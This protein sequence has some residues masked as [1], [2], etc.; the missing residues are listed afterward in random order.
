[1]PGDP[2]LEDRPL[3]CPVLSN[4]ENDPP[5]RTAIYEI[6]KS[7]GCLCK[8][9]GLSHDRFDRTRLKQRDNSVPSVP[10]GLLRLTEHVEAQDAGLWHDEI[11][12]VNGRLAACG[13]SQCCEASSW[14]ERFECLAQEFTS[15]AV[16]DDIC[17]IAVRD[18]T[19]AISQ[20]L[21]RGIDDLIESERLRLLGFRRVSRA[22]YGVFCSQ[23]AGQLC[24]RV[25]DRSPNRWCQDGFART[26]TSQGKS[27]LR[28]EI[29]D[30]NACGAYIVDTIRYQAKIFLPDG[31]PLTVSS[32]LKS[33]IG[34]PEHYA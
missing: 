31:N 6:T 19:D 30:R 3:E 24:H 7:I 18:T 1:M 32:I 12:H 4:R 25:A 15:D 8:R 17:A 26:K 28:G 33:S 22:R 21:Q 20:L 23:C 27:Y 10:N 34:A 9:K 14:R 29:R 2:F 16:D 5:K 11:C 13:I